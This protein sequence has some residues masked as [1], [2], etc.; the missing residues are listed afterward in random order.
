MNSRLTENRPGED[1][2]RDAILGAIQ[3]VV[4]LLL[5]I[6]GIKLMVKLVLRTHNPSDT[7][8]AP[9]AV[10]ATAADFLSR[11]KFNVLSAYLY[12]ATGAVDGTVAS[13]SALRFARTLLS[14]V[15]APPPTFWPYGGPESL[16][17]FCCGLA[18]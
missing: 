1:L 4:E 18:L 15:R 10:F 2:G 12:I 7:I 8:D 14:R 17:S 5:R 9:V 6:P 16:R 13:E 3:L 11:T